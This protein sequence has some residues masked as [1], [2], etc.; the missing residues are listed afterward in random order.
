MLTSRRKEKKARALGYEDGDLALY[1]E[2]NASEFVHD[3]D[4]LMMLCK[5]NRVVL[6]DEKLTNSP[7]TTDEVKECMKDIKV[8][9]PR[10]L[11]TILSWRKKILGDIVKERKLA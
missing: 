3:A 5:A 9:G 10:E 1:H 6:D 4:Y 8:C 7:H 2:L 11:R